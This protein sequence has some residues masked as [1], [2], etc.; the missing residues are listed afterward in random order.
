[1]S[2]AGIIGNLL[3]YRSVNEWT[4]RSKTIRRIPAKRLF[5]LLLLLQLNRLCL[6]SYSTNTFLIA[7]REFNQN[8]WLFISCNIF[9]ILT[10]SNSLTLLVSLL[11]LNLSDEWNWIHLLYIAWETKTNKNMTGPKV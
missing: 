3:E 5:N 1:M 10:K 9:L 4:G 2:N 7:Q 8:L 11:M 6:N